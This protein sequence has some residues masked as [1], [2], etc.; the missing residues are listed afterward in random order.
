MKGNPP[1]PIEQRIAQGNP[2]H[3]PLP[4]VVVGLGKTKEIEQPDDLT[5]QE[6]DVW[7]EL[8]PQILGLGWIDLIDQRLNKQYVQMTALADRALHDLSRDD[9]TVMTS[10][11]TPAANPLYRIYVDAS[12]QAVQL[13]DRFGFNPSARARLGLTTVKGMSIAADLEKRLGSDEQP[14]TIEVDD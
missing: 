13:A 9:L 5:S 4:E 14:M 7:N 12:K 10:K 11:G 6:V 2:G 3:R 1:T 8:V